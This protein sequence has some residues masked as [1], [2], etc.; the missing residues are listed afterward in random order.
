[1]PV[2]VQSE[3]TISGGTLTV[4]LSNTSSSASLNPA[5]LL[6]SYYFDIVNAS[7]VRPNLQLSSA[8]GDV[9]LTSQTQDDV[10]TVA[11]ADLSPRMNKKDDTWQFISLDG[12]APLNLGFGVGTVGN[13]DLSGN[14]FNGSIVGGMDYALYAGDVSTRNL[15]GR[16]LV[17]DSITFTFTG[18]SG[19][20]EGDI[21][22]DYVFGLGTSPETL[23]ETPPDSQIPPVVVPE[24]LTL[25]LFGLGVVGMG[26]Y[27]RRR[28]SAA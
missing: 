10:L 22:P 27:I 24:P 4:K 23:F 6:T 18:V 14:N 20:D 8:T 3:L 28:T 25:G 2:S 1:M 19:F 7:G 26:S 21:S 16:L 5:D 9:W 13:S 12:S 15:D 11:N 17:K